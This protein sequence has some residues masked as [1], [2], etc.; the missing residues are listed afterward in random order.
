MKNIRKDIIINTEA[1]ESIRLEKFIMLCVDH[2]F[3]ISLEYVF[4]T[5][6]RIYFMMN[7]I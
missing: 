7:Y 2:P 1:I 6:Y 4:H 3:I 5:E